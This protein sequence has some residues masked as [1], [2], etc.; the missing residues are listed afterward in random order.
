M[1]SID[2]KN[3][4]LL[5]ILN[6]ASWFVDNHEI[7][8]EHLHQNGKGV[9]ADPW[10]NDQYKWETINSG[11]THTGWPQTATGYSIKPDQIKYKTFNEEIP[12]RYDRIN[13]ELMHYFGTRHNALFHVY[14]PEG[15]LSW[16]NNANA[17]S[18]N[19]IFTYNPTG[20]GYFAYHDWETNETIKM[21]DKPGWSCKAGFF[22]S[23]KEPKEKL[24]YHCAYTK[25][26]RMTV[27]YIWGAYDTEIGREF[28]QQVIEDIS[29]E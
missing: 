28:Q 22:A 27:S 3:K 13:T 21:K 23:Y 7:I 16:H 11:T 15:F 10:I 18:Q 26:W 6:E 5:S 25:V 29:I 14:P 1:Q 17:S 8:Q 24:V 19:V 9:L 12:N 2:I 20:D 4:E